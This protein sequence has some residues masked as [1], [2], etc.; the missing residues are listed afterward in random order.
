MLS[1][2]S[3]FDLSEKELYRF[4]TERSDLKDWSTRM[5][6]NRGYGLALGKCY[7]STDLK[8]CR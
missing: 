4:M 5:R 6:E 8:R 7:N 2:Y 1:Q 3:A